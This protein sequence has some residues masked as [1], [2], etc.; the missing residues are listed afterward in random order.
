VDDEAFGRF[1]AKRD[2]IDEAMDWLVRTRVKPTAAINDDS[3]PSAPPPCTSPQ[4]SSNSCGGQSL[5]FDTLQ[6][7]TGERQLMP[8]EVAQEVQL[9]VKYEG[10]I[11]RQEEQIVRF[12]KFEEVLLP[13]DLEYATFDGLSNEVVE[14][15]TK[16]RPRS[17]GQASRISGITPAAI[18]VLQIH[19]KKRGLI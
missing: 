8:P 10:Y 4:A 17:L 19:L 11:R 18:A 15:L 7:V 3:R 2:G 12:R 9:Q 16:I 1:R 14:K 13:D 6:Q 5:T